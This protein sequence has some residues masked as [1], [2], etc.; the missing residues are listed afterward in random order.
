MKESISRRRGAGERALIALC[1]FTLI[2]VA[3]GLAYA[4]RFDLV[5][6]ASRI[7]ELQIG[8]LLAVAA[9]GTAFL[10]MGAHKGFWR[11]VGL[12]DLW[13]LFG[14]NVIGSLLF[15][16]VVY[17]FIGDTFPRAVYG[18]D[19]AVC[20][21][22]TV[23]FRVS[24]RT[25]CELKRE[26]GNASTKR[27]L[28]YGAGAAGVALAREL[29]ANPKLGMV[30]GFL[31]DDPNKL[32]NSLMGVPVKG[33]GRSA[34]LIVH[35]CA[36]SK[37]PI[38][39]IIIAMPSATGRQMREAIAN[40]KASGVGC[41]T[42]PGLSELLNGKV[43]SKQIR[44]VAVTDLLGREPVEMEEDKVRE[45]IK[46]RSV[47]I[48][49][50]AGSIGSELCRQIARFQPKRLIIF[51]QAESEVFKIE[52]ELRERFPQL[53]MSAVIGDIRCYRRVD[54]VIR[55]ERVESIFH[56]AA[57]KHVP[58]M[59]ANI[60][61]AVQNNVL[62]T[63]ILAR[64]ASRNRVPN[65]LMVS[66]DKAVNP[67]NV[68]GA[69]K[70]VAELIVSGMQN[71]PFNLTNF[72]A[73]RFGN[74]LGSNGSVVPTF[75]R[76]I[77]VGGP[78]TI[79]HPDITRYFMTIPEAVQLVLQAS[80][81]GEGAEIFVLEM[82]DP[83]RIVDLARN[84]I[85]LAGLEPDEDIEIRFIGLRPGEKLFEE[86]ITEGENI[87]PTYHN[88]IKIFR[89]KGIALS[90]LEAWIENTEMLLEDRDEDRLMEQLRRLV[91]EFKSP[92]WNG[93][94]S[95]VPPRTEPGV[96][97]AVSGSR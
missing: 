55:R 62:G 56:A 72:V 90:T 63:W 8:M 34:P 43:L 73:V 16:A 67:T 91:P 13:R 66:S 93:S 28:I 45:K 96:A 75:R 29:H 57:Y 87:L 84:M 9:K 31:D 95:V 5:V 74:V 1:F 20:V 82:G 49:G 48:T 97:S 23:A 78:V 7:R 24:V 69:T 27:V 89:G 46:G 68:M 71:A 52:M 53:S 19:A 60:S 37:T 38:N 85:R 77:A 76:Q 70:R 86:L 51:D 79:T 94:D 58:L 10:A 88:K 21:L 17:P 4:L 11:Y 41:K 44:D 2:G 80:T 18:I 35:R 50:A 3:E 47:M 59:E 83:V 32:G 92:R 22:L 15:I 26:S 25:Y 36:K 12:V 42:V 30:V 64:C 65:F 61:E 81:M 39:E 40:C 6:P 14:A 54:E 33:S